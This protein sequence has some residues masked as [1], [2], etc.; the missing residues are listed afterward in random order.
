M[1]HHHRSTT[2]VC[3]LAK[4]CR[5]TPLH[6]TLRGTLS[7]GRCRLGRKSC[8]R[9]QQHQQ[10]SGAA[11]LM[12]LATY[13]ACQSCS[14]PSNTRQRVVQVVLVLV[15]VMVMQLV[16]LVMV[17]QLVAM[18]EHRRIQQRQQQHRKDLRLSSFTRNLSRTVCSTQTS[19]KELMAQGKQRSQAAGLMCWRQR[20][21][22]LLH[23]W[24]RR[25]KAS[26]WHH[27]LLLM[28]L[29]LLLHRWLRSAN[30]CFIILLY[31][32]KIIKNACNE[33]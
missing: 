18:L 13:R 28:R 15:L 8:W 20:W 27:L 6:T 11:S 26:R 10:C 16:L 23:G 9:M 12:T 24:N 31:F 2:L 3:G 17:M 22:S 4:L 21:G 29:L 33:K 19:S 14:T 30:E 25:Q 1:G 32:K 7:P 5:W